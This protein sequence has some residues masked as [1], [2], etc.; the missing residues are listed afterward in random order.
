M[1]RQRG[2]KN[3][4]RKAKK[5]AKRDFRLVANETGQMVTLEPKAAGKAGEDANPN[6]VAAAIATQLGMRDGLPN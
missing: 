4:D 5:Y 3:N 6:H 1:T 2:N